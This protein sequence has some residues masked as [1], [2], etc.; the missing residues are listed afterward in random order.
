M[1]YYEYKEKAIEAI[2]EALI[3]ATIEFLSKYVSSK[4]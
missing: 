3:D 1:S 4:L 2:A